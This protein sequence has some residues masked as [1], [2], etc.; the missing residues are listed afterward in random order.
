MPKARSSGTIASEQSNT[1]VSETSNRI[2]SRLM[3]NSSLSYIGSLA[4]LGSCEEDSEPGDLSSSGDIEVLETIDAQA[5]EYRNNIFDEEDDGLFYTDEENYQSFLD[6]LQNPNR[7]SYD[8]ENALNGSDI[9]FGIELEFVD[10][11]SDAIAREL[12]DLGICSSPRMQGYHSSNSPSKWKLER[13]GTVTNGRRGGELVSPVLKDTPETWRN[14]EKICEVAKRHGARINQQCGAHVHIGMEPLN[15]AR[16][17]WRRMFRTLGGFEDIIYRVSGGSLGRIR[18]NHEAYATPFAQR[19]RRTATSRF[20]LNDRRDINHLAE[21]ASVHSRYYGVNLTNIYRS[22][23]PDTVEFRYFNG[24]LDPSVLQTNI[25]VANGIIM[26]SQKA[27]SQDSSTYNVTDNF[28]RRGSLLRNH[29]MNGDNKND[30]TLRKFVD[31]IFTRKKDK[32][33]LISLYSKNNW[34]S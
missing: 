6:A 20:T 7:P 22:H 29:N 32:D 33:S 16:Q 11:N 31:I 27:R 1:S 18:S 12:Y 8:Y 15:T 28:K 14:L 9:T 19:A 24:S 3:N 2:R 5:E 13:D 26:A 34:A 4:T 10:G 25:K 17:R 30:N 21:C 23:R